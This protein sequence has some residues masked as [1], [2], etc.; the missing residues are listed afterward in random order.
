MDQKRPADKRVNRVVLVIAN[1]LLMALISVALG[2]LALSLLD[3]WSGHG[4]ELTVPDVVGQNYVR[5]QEKLIAGGF[6]VE[7]ADSVYDSRYGRGVVVDQNPHKDTRVKPGRLIYV[8]VNATSPK[9]VTVPRLTDIS[10]RQAR[11]I[12]IGLGVKDIEEQLVMSEF[13]DLVLGARYNGKRLQPG[14]R[15]PVNARIVLEV[16]DGMPEFDGIVDTMANAPAE[17]VEPLNLD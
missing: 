2:W 6:Q 17:H 15:V 13:K 5:A 9:S 16:G 10:S 3:V 11:A 7:V 8:T 12:L 4:K 14:A 1:L